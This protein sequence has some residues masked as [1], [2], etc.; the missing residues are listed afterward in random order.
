MFLV[1]VY[2]NQHFDC[3]L[4]VICCMRSCIEC[5]VMVAFKKFHIAE[6]FRFQGIQPVLSIN[7]QVSIC[8][9]V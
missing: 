6:H 3:V 4:T 7:L 1:I 9:H 8:T 5:G 2:L